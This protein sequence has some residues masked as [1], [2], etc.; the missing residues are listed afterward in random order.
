MSDL[1]CRINLDLVNLQHFHRVRN[2]GGFLDLRIQFPSHNLASNLPRTS[3]S[4]DTP[5]SNNSDLTCQQIAETEPTKGM[6]W[7]KDWV[8]ALPGH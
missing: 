2:T 4:I 8:T 6:I 5:G 1:A 3:F 7:R